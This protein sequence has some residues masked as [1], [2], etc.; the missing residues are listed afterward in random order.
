MK[1]NEA[2]Y[3]GKEN[4]L[5]DPR[6]DIDGAGKPAY[7]IKRR[8]TRGATVL[9]SLLVLAMIVGGTVTGV[10]MKSGSP[11][12]TP[13]Q[14]S[15]VTIPVS[16]ESNQP[17]PASNAA[18]I[19]LQKL[20][21]SQAPGFTLTDQ[22]GRQISLAQLDRSHAVVLAFMDDRC[23]DVCPIVA[24]E[25]ADAYRDLG[26]LAS[27]VEFVS[28]NVNAAH[29]SL[30]WLRSFIAEQ[31]HALADVPTF[32]YVTGSASAL[33]R[34][35]HEYG[36]TVKVDPQTGAVYHSEGMYFI[37][38]GGSNR[39]E[40]TPFANLRKNGT[41]WLPATTITQWGRGIAQYAKAVL[42]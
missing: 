11:P 31:G 1:T 33:Q 14:L 24:R 22:N 18:L 27:K 15:K 16:G 37:A 8:S 17:I 35:W 2:R 23:R 30:H 4:V 26:R 20:S 32:H 19:G 21:A 6:P 3:A 36:I 40:A 25:I 41:G 34:V 13:Q 28:V 10:L 7:P 42:K 9:I 5:V 39:Y 12:A 38:P 29:D